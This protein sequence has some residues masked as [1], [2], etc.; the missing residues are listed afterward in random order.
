VEPPA[1]SDDTLTVTTLNLMSDLALWEQ[2]GPLIA[3]ELA[4][5]APDVI[6][7]QE[8][9]LPFDTATWLADR[10][11]GY[12]VLL[13]P[14]SRRSGQSE[15]VAILSR[16]PVEHHE[17]IEFGAQNRV[18]QKVIVRHGSTRWEVAN[19]HLHWS[20]HDDDTRVGQVRRMMD[21]LT[22]DLPTVV[23]GDFNARPSYRA[24]AAARERFD[25]AYA[26]A[27]GHEPEF[28]FPH[29]L[30]RGPRVWPTPM[31]WATRLLR[32]M[33]TFRRAPWRATVDYILVERGIQVLRCDT[34][35]AHPAP[36]QPH[37][38]PSDHVG[39]TAVLAAPGRPVG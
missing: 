20:I 23:C 15:A 24:L 34:C 12:E 10:L 19:A 22:S 17:R 18:A 6:A 13:G 29:A 9:V 36:G 4:R 33:L 26:L 1:G 11:G 25:S 7:F 38:Y 37:L 39:L 27:N 31:R 16:L 30:Y 3:D 5:L 21:W 35:F 28:T 32:P 2:R 8:V 14:K